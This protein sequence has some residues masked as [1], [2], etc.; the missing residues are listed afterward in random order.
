[1]FFFIPCLPPSI[2]KPECQKRYPGAHYHLKRTTS[3][4]EKKPAAKFQ[5]NYNRTYNNILLTKFLF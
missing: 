3:D 2:I 1:M 4:I 5:L